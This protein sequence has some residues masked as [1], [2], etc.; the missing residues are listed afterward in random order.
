MAPLAFMKLQA[1]NIL[2]QFYYSSRYNGH[3]IQSHFLKTSFFFLIANLLKPLVVNSAFT[4]LS[5]QASSVHS[6]LHRPPF[7]NNPPKGIHYHTFLSNRFNQLKKKLGN[8]MAVQWLGLLAFTAKG[9]GSVTGRG[10]RIPQ[11]S[12]HG[13]KKIFFFNLKS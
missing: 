11:A 6:F 7:S 10:T 8:S 12:G 2:N 3:K 1:Y 13:Q 5:S 4:G 9:R